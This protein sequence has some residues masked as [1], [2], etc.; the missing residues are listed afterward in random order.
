MMRTGGISFTTR[1][2]SGLTLLA[3][4]AALPAD[5]RAQE[6]G[7]SVR[8][9]AY[10][11]P[12]AEAPPE[13]SASQQ[14]QLQ[15][16]LKRLASSKQAAREAACEDVVAFGR[17]ALP[18]LLTEGA[19]R[20]EHKLPAVTGCLVRLADARDW[21]LVQA[22]LD[23]EHLALRR[24]A[25][26][27]AGQLA[28]P[29]LLEALPP[30]LAD[31]DALVRREAA[32]ALAAHGDK[33]ALEPL[34]AA[35][36]GTIARAPAG[37]GLTPGAPAPAPTEEDLALRERIRA[38]LT[39]LKDQSSLSALTRHLEVDPLRDREDPAGAAAERRAAV[40][41]L[42]AVGDKWALR[43]LARALDDPHNLV[44]RDAIDALRDLLE[45]QGPFEGG[46]IFA[47]INE[48]K[49]LRTL[50]P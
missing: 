39:G 40:A 10:Q 29:P 3:A 15:R 44:Q 2:L 8:P 21:P 18:A 34:V 46:S 4:Y 25:A 33:R 13:L 26:I 37:H 19:T 17:G 24:F 27:K 36:V 43:G 12:E 23:S 22:Q 9:P 16:A 20:H 28:L 1:I 49:R 38:S 47:Q 41:M 30:L 48:V 35:W 42:R 11:L 5:A 14:Q 50:L 32:L 7:T 45:G 31:D 6:R